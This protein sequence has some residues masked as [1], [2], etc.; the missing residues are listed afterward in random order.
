MTSWFSFSVLSTSK[1]H[2]MG[3]DRDCYRISAKRTLPIRKRRT[4]NVNLRICNVPSTPRRLKVTCLGRIWNCTVLSGQVYSLFFSP[5]LWHYVYKKNCN[6]YWM[7][8]ARFIFLISLRRRKDDLHYFYAW[9][10]RRKNSHSVT[11]SFTLLGKVRFPHMSSVKSR[12][13][14]I[15]S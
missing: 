7:D 11:P 8:W 5:F 14:K 12:V 4:R 2:P 3:R 10:Y 9:S 15:S 6:N 13:L 1:V